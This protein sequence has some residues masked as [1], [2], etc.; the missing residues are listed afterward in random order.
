MYPLLTSMSCRREPWSES[1]RDPVTLDP[2]IPVLM[3]ADACREV[4]TEG[5]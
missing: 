1:I 2:L 5:L 4:V 3:I